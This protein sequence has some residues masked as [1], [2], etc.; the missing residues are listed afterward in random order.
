MGKPKSGANVE[1]TPPPIPPPLSSSADESSG[2]GVSGSASNSNGNYSLQTVNQIPRELRK[3]LYQPPPAFHSY[4]QLMGQQSNFNQMQSQIPR[5]PYSMNSNSYGSMMMN[6]NHNYPGSSTQWRR[7]GNLLY[8]PTTH[9]VI[10]KMAEERTRSTFSSIESVLEAFSS[11]NMILD[12]TYSAIHGSFKTITGVADHLIFVRNHFAE[13]ALIPRTLQI[14]SKFCHWLLQLFGIDCSKWIKSNQSAE[15]IWNESAT[16]STESNIKKLLTHSDNGES[17][18]SPL[19]PIFLFFSLVFGTPYIVWR[20][21]GSPGSIPRTNCP[22]W[23]TNRGRHFVALGVY[24]FKARN[25]N[26]L[27][28]EKN[29]ILFIKPESLQPNSKWLIACPTS[30]NSNGTVKMGLIPLNY[31]KLIMK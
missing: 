31:V 18:S 10:S 12:S 2:D 29:Q 4:P 19:W 24:D 5:T 16:D 9:G 26:E 3:Y 28:F 23:T 21:L 8:D 22:E 15:Q 27:S 7:A 11:I 14:I 13:I 6:Y 25:E 17:V 30:N 20:L 1:P